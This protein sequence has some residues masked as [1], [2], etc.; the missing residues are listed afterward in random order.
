MCLFLHL[1]TLR[2][3][4]C[5]FESFNIIAIHNYALRFTS[6]LDFS[7]SIFIESKWTAGPIMTWKAGHICLCLRRFW[8]S[9][10]L[11]ERGK[12]EFLHGCS[13]T[14][15]LFEAWTSVTICE[16][17]QMVIV[18]PEHCSDLI[19]VW[20]R[21]L[22]TSLVCDIGICWRNLQGWM[23][24]ELYCF[25]LFLPLGVHLIFNSWNFKVFNY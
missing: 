3:I 21:H 17:R 13:A 2:K 24:T 4:T 12:D 19:R 5:T 1:H 14:S 7:Q 8:T 16:S 6:G 15:S 9:N 11:V 10:R 22:L 18:L 25:F 20:Q 23:K